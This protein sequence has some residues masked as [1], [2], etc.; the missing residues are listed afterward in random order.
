MV[1]IGD[2]VTRVPVTFDRLD[3]KCRRTGTPLRGTAVWIHPQNRFH[4]VEF[5]TPGGRIRES[6]QGV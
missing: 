3:D 6:F 5:D 1:R 4:V 2:R